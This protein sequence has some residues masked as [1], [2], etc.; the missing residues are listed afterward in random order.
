MT[1]HPTRIEYL[2]RT[3]P[4]QSGGD[5]GLVHDGHGRLMAMLAGRGEVA[6]ALKGIEPVYWFTP[7]TRYVRMFE[8]LIFGDTNHL[9]ALQ[10]AA[11]P[12]VVFYVMRPLVGVGWAWVMTAFFMLL[13][14]GNVSFLQYM[15]Y[16]R[17][18]YGEAWGSA[19]FL[20]GTAL[21]FRTQ[22]RWGG[23]DDRTSHVWC[24]GAA[25]AASMFIRPNLALA[26]VWLAIAYAWAS[27]ADRQLWRIAVLALG[28]GLA[29]WMPFH[30]WVY[31]REFYLIS[32]SG[33][34]LSVPLGVGDYAKATAAALTGSHTRE[35][36]VVASQIKGWLL[37][38][39]FVGSG[40]PAWADIPARIV[41]L[42][43]LIVT[44][45]IALKWLAGRLVGETALGVLAMAAL[46]AHAPLLFVFNT[47]YRYAVLAWD[48]S[49]LV[50][51]V[52]V[53]RRPMME[54]RTVLSTV[55]TLTP[56]GN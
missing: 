48:L 35:T 46:F 39:G 8:K 42:I 43:S 34:T 56:A 9:F 26:V 5:D 25:L 15:T 6:E 45:W 29:L 54:S 31:G 27:W 18:G 44:A 1:Y 22:P 3:Y 7:G 51:F 50:L 28:L 21:L 37:D 55:P 32:K 14:A 36:D 41:R 19:L 47:Y 38:P 16:A 23:V 17:V 53:V 13:P 20:A 24:A 30:N 12:I 2:G 11:F 4:P 49:L 52:A 10:L 40:V 33:A